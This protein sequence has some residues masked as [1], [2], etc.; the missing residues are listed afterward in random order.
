MP[1]LKDFPV[2][3]DCKQQKDVGLV[4]E[5]FSGTCRLSKACRKFGLRALPVDK[6][7]NRAESCTVASYD[8]ADQQQYKTLVEVLTAEKQSLVHAHCA[9]S[10]GTASRARGRKMQGVPLHMQPRSLRSDEFPDGLQDLTEKEQLRVDSANAS[11]EATA[12]LILLLVGWGVS[13][14]IENPA[15]SLFWKTSWIARLLQ[16]LPGG[17][18][19]ILDHCMHGGARDKTT[20]FWSYNPLRPEENMLSSLAL[21]C[22]GNHA[23]K[24]WKPSVKDGVAFFPTKEEAAYPTVLCERLA[25]IFLCWAKARNLEGPQDFLEQT[26]AD[27]DVANDS[28][29]Q[30]NLV[31]RSFYKQFQSLDIL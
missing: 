22:D 24:S 1:D 12:E 6:D 17:H 7:P 23:H 8:L 5:I 27:A 20:R 4:V 31:Q 21:R 10:C 28:C 13:V 26:A 29:S 15:N 30:D 11:Y 25:S 9:P 19:T 3:R 2:L 14:S 16:K 18:D